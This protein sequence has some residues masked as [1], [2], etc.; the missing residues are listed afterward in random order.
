[1]Q[2]AGVLSNDARICSKNG[3]FKRFGTV[4]GVIVEIEGRI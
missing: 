1:M 2:E 3:I 4:P